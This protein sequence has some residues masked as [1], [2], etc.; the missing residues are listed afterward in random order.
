MF[1]QFRDRYGLDR[2]I[3]AHTLRHCF[4]T[5]CLE[6]GVSL[7]HIQEMLG[8]STIKTTTTYLHLT[9]KSLMGV[10]SPLDAALRA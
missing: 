4:A 7:A 1:T 5:H 10:K 6:Q 9:A 3:S 8:H 2:R